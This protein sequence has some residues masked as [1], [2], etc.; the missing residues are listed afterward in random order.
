MATIRYNEHAQIEPELLP[1]LESTLPLREYKH[2]VWWLD[3]IKINECYLHKTAI[4]KGFLHD[5]RA[6]GQDAVESTVDNLSTRN[7]M[8]GFAPATP[9][10]LLPQAPDRAVPINR[11]KQGP[12]KQATLHVLRISPWEA[13]GDRTFDSIG[14]PDVRKHE[15]LR[16][17]R[18][19]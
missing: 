9:T 19:I 15:W 11:F 3:K 7:V 5:K 6:S 10:T 18:E 2:W 8:N 1:R 12:S 4:E 17:Q 16:G 14:I 13:T